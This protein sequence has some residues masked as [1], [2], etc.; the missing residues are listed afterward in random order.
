MTK[1]GRGMGEEIR[2]HV[3]GNF[4]RWKRPGLGIREGGEG[5]PQE[6]MKKGV[7]TI[8]KWPLKNFCPRKLCTGK[9]NTLFFFFFF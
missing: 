5:V 7:D 6:N 4:M 9:E 3:T 8:E 1:R 2:V